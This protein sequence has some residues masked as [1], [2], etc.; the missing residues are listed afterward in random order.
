MPKPRRK[1]HDALEKLAGEEEKFLEAEFLAPVVCGGHVAV[2]IAGV[3]CDLRLTPRD[4]EGIGVFKPQ[5]HASARL[6]REATMSQRR[7]YL[8]LFPRVL[9]AIST[10]AAEGSTTA[11]AVPI[12]AADARFSVDGEIELRLVDEAAEL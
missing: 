1:I 7:K 4:F 11:G 9:L 2:R 10:R 5:S 8:Q 3:V 12:N 6:V